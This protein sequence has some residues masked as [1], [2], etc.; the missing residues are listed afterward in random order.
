M[1]NCNTKNKFFRIRYPLFFVILFIG[2]IGLSCQANIPP[3]DGSEYV[4]LYPISFTKT[5]LGDGYAELV[6]TIAIANND[7]TW[8]S[9]SFGSERHYPMWIG[10]TEGYTYETDGGLST[11]YVL[12]AGFQ[13]VGVECAGAVN[14]WENTIRAKVA[15]NSSGY[16]L[17]LAGYYDQSK[18]IL[19]NTPLVVNLTN[20]KPFTSPLVSEQPLNIHKIGETVSLPEAT[21]SIKNA[22]RTAD[23]LNIE[24]DFANLDGGYETRIQADSYLIGNDGLIRKSNSACGELLDDT[25]EVDFSAGPGQT[26]SRLRTFYVPNSV[27]N[28]YF[29][30]SLGNFQTNVSDDVLVFEIP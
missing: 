28:L 8:H 13:M 5:S 23:T 25:G 17:F 7:T 18:T 6:A 22:S 29:V 20:T 1:I 14:G 21:L 2:L 9:F 19:F 4:S 26:V 15:E 16:S 10:T 27:N 24:Y 12:P 11:S 3:S 30:I